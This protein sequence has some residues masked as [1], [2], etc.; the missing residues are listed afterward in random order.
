LTSPTSLT[1][2]PYGRAKTGSNALVPSLSYQGLPSAGAANFKLRV[3]NGIPGQA[4]VILQS[5]ASASTAYYGGT[6]FVADPTSSVASYVLD[7]SGQALVP[8]AIS[9]SM[10][11]TELY[12]QAVFDDPAAPQ[13][14]GLTNGLVVD[15]GP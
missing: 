13:P 5:T 1:P 8:I 4:G 12:Y 14:H 11:G 15:F 6:K 10:V 2:I 9:P 7:G 3:T